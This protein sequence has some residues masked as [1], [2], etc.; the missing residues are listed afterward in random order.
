MATIDGEIIVKGFY[1]AA[2][3]KPMKGGEVLPVAVV[4]VTPDIE[5]TPSQNTLL[6]RNT[7]IS[8]EITS[9]VPFRRVFIQ[10][11]YSGINLWEVVHNGDSF[12]PNYSNN[13]NVRASLVNG[14]SY[15]L[16][17]NGGWPGAPEF[18]VFAVDMFGN[19]NS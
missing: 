4:S 1:A 13:V 3:S 9:G 7:P 10:A 14:Y 15:T 11:K 2:L 17:R 18:E 16:M 8:L 19:E 5:V 6:S 12:S